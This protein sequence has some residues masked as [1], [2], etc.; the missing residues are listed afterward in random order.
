M[1]MREY[2]NYFDLD[3]IEVAEGVWFA[4]WGTHYWTTTSEFDP[5]AGCNIETPDKSRL[6]V[7][8]V[9]AFNEDDS[10]RTLTPDEIKAWSEKHG[11]LLMEQ[12]HD[13]EQAEAEAHYEAAAE[14]QYG[15]Y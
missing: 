15:R 14:A 13:A 12:V 10:E 6:V 5:E 4:A 2:D 3:E 8:G 1:K 7:D 11:D 9:V